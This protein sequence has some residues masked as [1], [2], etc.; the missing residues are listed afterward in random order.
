MVS[1]YPVYVIIGR[2]Q[3]KSAGHIG[4]MVNPSSLFPRP[5]V[6]ATSFSLKYLSP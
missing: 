2:G 1:T 4:T 6:P 3:N 5:V